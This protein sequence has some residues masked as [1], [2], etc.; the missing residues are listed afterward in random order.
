MHYLMLRITLEN[1]Q[2]GHTLVQRGS[3]AFCELQAWST[4]IEQL[5][6]PGIVKAE[7]IVI[8]DEEWR[9]I[10]KFQVRRRG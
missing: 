4:D 5:R 3:R 9:K 6:G 8:S 7:L 2:Y 10:C 1:G